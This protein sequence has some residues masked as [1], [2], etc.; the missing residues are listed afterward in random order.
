MSNTPSYPS[1]V[2]MDVD[3]QLPCP[4]SCPSQQPLLGDCSAWGRA[5][6]EYMWVQ[7][8]APGWWTWARGPGSL[9]R[10]VWEGILGSKV[11][12][13]CSRRGLRF[14]VA[15]FLWVSGCL[16]PWGKD[17]G[18]WRPEQSPLKR[19]G[20]GQGSLL[21]SLRWHCPRGRTTNR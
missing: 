4:S 5:H 19:R 8:S 20:L 15:T 16:F 2:H 10:P 7:R 6:G 21:L 18:G 9:L 14:Q 13:R 12:G 3:Y 1:P 17:V 11:V